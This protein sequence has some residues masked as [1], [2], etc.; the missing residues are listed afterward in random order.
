MMPKRTRK[1]EIEKTCF[2]YLPLAN[3]HLTANHANFLG[4]RVLKKQEFT[5]MQCRALEFAEK[6][7]AIV[8]L[9]PFW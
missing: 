4:T 8:T 9:S 7:S 1:I 5:A 3:E 6:T 2:H